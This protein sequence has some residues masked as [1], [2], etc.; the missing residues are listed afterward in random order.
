MAADSIK[1]ISPT[2]QSERFGQTKGAYVVDHF[3]GKSLTVK[4]VPDLKASG[5]VSAQGVSP[6]FS[7]AWLKSPELTELMS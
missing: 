6:L 3:R 2:G 4:H 5:T 7:G 1:V